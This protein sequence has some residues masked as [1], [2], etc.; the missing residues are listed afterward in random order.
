MAFIT[1]K[2]GVN[3]NIGSYY[4]DVSG[5]LNVDGSIFQYGVPFTGGGSGGGGG[6]VSW[7]SGSVGSDNQIITANGDGSIVAESN[8][9]FSD[10]SLSFSN[11]GNR[12][13]TIDPGTTGR[14]L[15]I[16]ANNNSGSGA[17]G[18]LTLKSGL[19][20]AGTTGP[21][22][23]VYGGQ[24]AGGTG[25]ILYL[26][27]GETAGAIGGAVEIRGGNGNGAGAGISIKGGT[28]L[29][30][31]NGGDVSVNGGAPLSGNAG[32]I[33][34]GQNDTSAI[35]IGNTNNIPTGTP[36]TNQVLYVDTAAGYQIKRGTASGGISWSGST[37]NAVGTYSSSSVIVAE[38]NLIFDGTK[39]G[40][41]VASPVCTVDVSGTIRSQSATTPT[42]GTGIELFWNGTAGY[43]FP[44]DRDAAEYLP[45]FIRGT[46]LTLDPAYTGTVRSGLDIA[47]TGFT[48]NEDSNAMDFRVETESY[49]NNFFING[50]TGKTT[51]GPVSTAS[52]YKSLNVE[53]TNNAIDVSNGVGAT[54]DISTGLMIRNRST[55]A[56]SFANLDFSTIDTS[57]YPYRYSSARMAFRGTATV[58]ASDT[59]N[60]LSFI[61]YG[62][63]NTGHLE[64]FRMTRTGNFHAE[65]DIIAYST[66]ITSD[67]RLKKNIET[68]EEDSLGKLM[69]LRPVT[70][71][72]IK[73]RRGERASGFIAQE[74]EKVF[75]TL[76]SKN[77]KLNENPE[78]EYLHIRYNELIPHLTNAIKQ[79]QQQIENQKK[80][81]GALNK[82]IEEIIGKIS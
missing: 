50:T 24:S 30:G 54:T 8:L 79:Q 21:T 22:T 35:Y 39:L 58:T 19:S 57:T 66:T 43:L 38:S 68:I 52:T 36:G 29:S 72:W 78:E 10:G 44:Y 63:A 81:I 80:E 16:Q 60:Y 37:A 76:I 32:K 51:I 67:E 82:K 65:N 34:I 17:G 4:V 62:T 41:R 40:V 1:D 70:F 47:Y 69:Q 7:A 13:I 31:G 49:T 20:G 3:K 45:M 61:L 55:T 27:G 15:T 75:P 42:S 74:F 53:F 77:I 25:G 64:Q 56:N 73:E 9:K 18:S 2:I 12:Y 33:Y 71:D 46:A 48:F 28:P 14:S 6:N 59:T 11:T 5:T 23:Y 26:S